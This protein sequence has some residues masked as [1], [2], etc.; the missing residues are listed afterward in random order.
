MQITHEEAH[1]LIQFGMDQTLKPQEKNS[2]QTH[3]NDCI[4]CRSFAKEIHELET[5]LLPAMRRHW[6]LQPA[7]L[8]MEAVTSKR[9][10]QLAPSLILVTRTVIISI[11]FA[12]FV[13]TAWQFTVSNSRASTPM[14]VSVLP[15]PTPSGQSTSTKISLQNCEETTYQVQEND[16]LESLAAQFSVSTDKIMAINNLGTETINAKMELL[17][18]ICNST[19]TGT[20]HPST[21]TTT[22]TPLTGPTASASTPGG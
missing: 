16:T 18:P 7:P 1:E 2:L 14:P 22:F 5:L 20:V 10:K 15:I 19:P 8:S 17:I 6:N 12:A 21:L 11:V 13:F 3:L 9:K 4:E